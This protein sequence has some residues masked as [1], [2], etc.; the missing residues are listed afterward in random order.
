MAAYQQHWELEGVMKSIHTES[1]TLPW[2][3]DLG[4]RNPETIPLKIE[5]LQIETILLKVRDYRSHASGEATHFGARLLRRSLTRPEGQSSPVSLNL[6][7]NKLLRL[8]PGN[9]RIRKNHS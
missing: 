1:A 8:F 7:K 5:M 6:L 4:W 2:V 9:L 3:F